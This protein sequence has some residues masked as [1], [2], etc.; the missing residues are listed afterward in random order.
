MFLEGTEAFEIKLVW[1]DTAIRPD[2]FFYFS[3]HP[4]L[5]CFH[6]SHCFSQS[7][8]SGFPFWVTFACLT[9]LGLQ[10]TCSVAAAEADGVGSGE[11]GHRVG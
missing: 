7:A 1:T 10:A 4:S 3:Y 11:E 9:V 8:C 6:L 2:H 5:G